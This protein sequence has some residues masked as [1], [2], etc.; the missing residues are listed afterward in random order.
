VL[1]TGVGAVL[2]RLPCVGLAAYVALFAGALAA[3][4]TIVGLDIF[5][6]MPRLLALI[7]WGSILFILRHRIA[8]THDAVAAPA[9]ALRMRYGKARRELREWS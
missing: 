3:S 9:E 4:L 7:L 2:A 1:S 8:P 6:L 5:G